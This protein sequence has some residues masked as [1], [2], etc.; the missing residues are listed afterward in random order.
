MKNTKAPKAVFFLNHVAEKMHEANE[1]YLKYI[2]AF[3]EHQVGRKGLTK[4]T[5]RVVENNRPYKG[6]NFFDEEDVKSLEVIVRGE[7]NI[8]GFR[9]KDLR[10]HLPGKS[11]G[12]VSR[13]LKRMRLHGIIK[14]AARGYKYYLTEI[15]REVVITILKIKE[16]LIIPSLC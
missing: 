12:Q 6:F 11:P 10:K 1:R 14:K 5:N 13:L 3:S 2:S 9:N 16:M 4:V 15:A 8:G 7:I